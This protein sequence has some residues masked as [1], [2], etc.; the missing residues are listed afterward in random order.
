MLTLKQKAS[1]VLSLCVLAASLLITTPV[2][3]GGDG[4]ID[5][6]DRIGTVD[7][8]PQLL[9]GGDGDIDWPD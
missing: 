2:L 3:A 5:W 1:V 8:C 6:P 7:G 4:D 9:T